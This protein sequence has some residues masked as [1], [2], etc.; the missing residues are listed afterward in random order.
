MRSLRTKKACS[1]PSPAAPIAAQAIGTAPITGPPTAPAPSCRGLLGDEHA[2]GPERLR[3]QER[4]A[5]VDVVLGRAAARKRDL[6]DHQRVLAQGL[7]QRPSSFVGCGGCRGARRRYA[8]PPS[9]P[10]RRAALLQSLRDAHALRHA[11]SL[12]H[13]GAAL[14]AERRRRAGA[15]DGV[16][17]RRRPHRPAGAA[18]A[19][20]RG[21]P[22]KGADEGLPALQGPPDPL[23]SQQEDRARAVRRE[24]RLRRRSVAWRARSRRRGSSR[25]RSRSAPAPR[26]GDR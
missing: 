19:A 23:A 6:A 21:P 18:A 1:S 10:P 4:P 11:R 13:E 3:A 16:R 7:E 25:R 5:H 26:C 14:A 8:S 2:R 9:R 15:T 17:L 24:R 12:Q 20:G 22:Q